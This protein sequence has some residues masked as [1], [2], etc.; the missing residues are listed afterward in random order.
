MI[1]A[2]KQGFQISKPEQDEA[3]LQHLHCAHDAVQGEIDENIL[4]RR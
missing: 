1:T 2:W 4:T 3:H